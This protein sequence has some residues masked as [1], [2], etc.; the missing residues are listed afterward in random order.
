MFPYST[1]PR[2]FDRVLILM[3]GTAMRSTY[4]CLTVTLAGRLLARSRC[5]IIIIGSRI[6]RTLR[7]TDRIVW[8]AY[9]WA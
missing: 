7:V 9:R 1:A 6:T 3:G 5:C 8:Q 2:A 4:T